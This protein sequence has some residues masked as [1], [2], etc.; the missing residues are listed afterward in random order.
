MVNYTDLSTG[1]IDTWDWDFGDG[2]T[3]I[4]VDY[5]L[6]PV[7]I[8]ENFEEVIIV[9]PNPATNNLNIVFPDAKNRSLILRNMDGIQ[10]YEKTSFFKEEVNSFMMISV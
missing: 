4:K 10:V 6:I 1:N 3:E 9:Y 7:G 5:I 2:D 8:G